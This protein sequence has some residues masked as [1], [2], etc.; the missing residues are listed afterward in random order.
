MYLPDGT[1]HTI[2]DRSYFYNPVIVTKCGYKECTKYLNY[3]FVLYRICNLREHNKVIFKTEYL[4]SDY[5]NKYVLYAVD[6]KYYDIKNIYHFPFTDEVEHDEWMEEDTIFNFLRDAIETD[7]GHIKNNIV[8]PVGYLE[9]N[10]IVFEGPVQDS[11]NDFTIEITDGQ[12]IGRNIFV[13]IAI[14]TI[15]EEHKINS[16][17]TISLPDE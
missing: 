10:A 7:D 9:N 13:Y 6:D 5:G 11:N 4:P 8:L 15:S 1:I 16:Y 3:P 2:V 17:F 12:S 14:T